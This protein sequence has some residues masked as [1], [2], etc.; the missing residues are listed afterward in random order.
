M[1]TKASLLAHDVSALVFLALPLVD[2]QRVAGFARRLS[3]SRA[4]DIIIRNLRMRMLYLRIHV[5]IC[6]QR[7]MI[8]PETPELNQ[9][10][11]VRFCGDSRWNHGISL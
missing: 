6:I 10:P 1:I 2:R 8:A 5:Y 7:C 9:C 4:V 11:N 3:A